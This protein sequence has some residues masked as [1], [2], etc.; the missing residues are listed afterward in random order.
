V[1]HSRYRGTC[2][3][4]GDREVPNCCICGS[5][6]IVGF[7]TGREFMVKLSRDSEQRKANSKRNASRSYPPCQPGGD[8]RCHVG[9]SSQRT[10]PH[11]ERQVCSG[12][13]LKWDQSGERANFGFSLNGPIAQHIY[14]NNFSPNKNSN[15][16]K[17]KSEH[18]INERDI[19]PPSPLTTSPQTHCFMEYSCHYCTISI[20]ALRL[21]GHTNSELELPLAVRARCIDAGH[22]RHKHTK[23]KRSRSQ[24]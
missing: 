1:R 22:E 2:V 10:Q 19:P 7:T 16:R 21:P 14:N 11:T 20:H 12:L 17:E 13:G 9:A 18:V 23:N 8:L 5:L 4:R 3:S 15:I 24:S 6:Q